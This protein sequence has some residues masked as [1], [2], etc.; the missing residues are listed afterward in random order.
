MAATLTAALNRH[1]GDV[2]AR[3]F[4]GENTA[5][6]SVFIGLQRT[7]SRPLNAFLARLAG[8]A[9]VCDMGVASTIV[10]ASRDVDI[11]HLHNLHGYYLNYRKLLRAWRDRPVVWTWHDMWGATGRCGQSIDCD[12]WKSRCGA[13]PHKEFYPSAWLDVSAREHR[14]KSQ[15]LF[16]HPNLTIV[17][18]SAW[19]ADIAKTRGFSSDRIR[20]IPNPVDLEVFALRDKRDARRRIGLEEDGLIALF[21]ARDCGDPYKGYADFVSAALK[22]GINAIAVGRMPPAPAPFVGHTGSIHD[23]KKLADYY[24]AADCMVIT[25]SADTYPTTVI[26]AIAC[27]TPVYGYAVGGVPSQIPAPDASLVARGNVAELAEKLAAF[28]AAQGK[29]NDISNALR[30]Y[31]IERWS[32]ARIANE[33]AGLYRRVFAASGRPSSQVIEFFSSKKNYKGQDQRR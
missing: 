1:V 28:A 9:A 31:A 12:R 7:A 32:V 2:R 18:P 17:T 11:L 16:T 22:A 3:L 24:A 5:R 8:S 23:P 26:E 10:R 25:S 6:N 14:L 19:M 20:I 4:H 21:V 33:Y 27:G 13:C 15:L 29:N 30:A